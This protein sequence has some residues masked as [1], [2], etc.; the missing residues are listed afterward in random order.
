MDVA[1]VW[2][3]VFSKHSVGHNGR[4][5]Q[6]E[7]DILRWTTTVTQPTRGEIVWFI[8]FYQPGE[9]SGIDIKFIKKAAFKVQN[10]LF[11][12]L[13]PTSPWVIARRITGPLH[14]LVIESTYHF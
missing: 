11:R 10:L 9:W 7:R 4:M 14:H 12:I 6:L 13:F 8:L 2:T 3:T 5:R 1:R